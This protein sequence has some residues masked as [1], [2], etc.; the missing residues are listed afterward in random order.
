MSPTGEWS[1]WEIDMMKA[2][3]AEMKEKCS[4]VE[5]SWDGLIPGLQAKKF[6]VI[7]SSMSITGE[8]EKV[9]D[10]TNKYYNTPSKLIAAKDTKPGTD[11]KSLTGKTIGIQVSTIQADYFKKHFADTSAAKTYSTLDEAFQDLAAGRIDYVFG[12]AIPLAEFLKSDFGKNCCAD[13]GD[14][15]DDPVILGTGIGGGLADREILKYPQVETVT[16]VDLD[17]E[18][19]R[20]F[21]THPMLTAL[22]QKSFSSPKVHITNADAFPWIDSST[23]SYDFIVIDFPDPTN[24]SLGKLYTTA[25]YKAVARHLSEQGLMVV[26]S[27]SPMFARDSYW[28]I[29]KTIQDAGLGTYPYH[30]YVPSFGEWGFV[31]AGRHSYSP[32]TSLPAGLRFIDVQGLTALFQFPPDMSPMQVPANHLNDQVLVRLYDKDWKDIS[33]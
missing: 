26:Q 30:V 32:P 1:G 33:H 5:M 18:M 31:I 14:V 25:F 13:M 10:F 4:I 27:T 8:R 16:L 17:P 7:W 15:A 28:C 21:S 6:D 23:D 3:C 11:A 9:I 19:T 29:A 12:D 24:Y 2:V 22:N 20:L